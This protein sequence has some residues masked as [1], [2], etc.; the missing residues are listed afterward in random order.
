M[1]GDFNIYYS[2][3][4]C[5]T[6][7]F[8]VSL[9]HFMSM[10]G[11]TQ[12]INTS[13]RIT[14]TTSTIVYLI[15]ISDRAKISQCGVLDL[16]LSAHQVIYCTRKCKKI[17]IS[18]HNGVT[19]RSLRNY[20]KEIFEEKLHEVDWQ[21]VLDSNYVHEAFYHFK[22]KLM[23]VIDNIAP[24]KYVHIKHRTATWMTV[25][26][27]HLIHERDRAFSKLRNTKDVSWHRKFIYLRNQ[28]Q[29]KKKKAK[30]DFIAN[31]TDEFKQQPN[32]LRQLLQS[33]GTST[34]CN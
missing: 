16:G 17:P 10:F 27:L 34:H 6:N 15:L 11:M 4:H 28:V 21:D 18:R 8:Y 12:L 33:L 9:K 30:S 3:M 29:Y 5:Y 23:V 7:Q 25:E 22:T 26:I 19:L 1:M 20:R 31:K 13:T 32:K 2:Q 24:L 14:S